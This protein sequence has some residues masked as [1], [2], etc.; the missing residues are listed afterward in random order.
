[1]CNRYKHRFAGRVVFPSLRYFS[2]G[3]LWEV[4]LRGGAYEIH[5]GVKQGYKTNSYGTHPQGNEFVSENGTKYSKDFHA[6][7]NSK[8]FYNTCCCG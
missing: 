1:M 3:A 2:H 8:G 4:E 6:P 5:C 7:E